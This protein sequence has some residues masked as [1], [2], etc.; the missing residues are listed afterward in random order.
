MSHCRFTFKKNNFVQQ[1]IMPETI[2]SMWGPVY[3][4]RLPEGVDNTCHVAE[5]RY[6]SLY[7]L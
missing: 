3:L 1:A 2:E 7:K 6:Q 4:P 5:H